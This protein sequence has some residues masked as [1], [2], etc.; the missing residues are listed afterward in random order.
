MALTQFKPEALWETW[1]SAKYT[2]NDEKPFETCI[3]AAFN[4]SKSD[5]YVY[6]AQGETTLPITQRVIAA[7]RANGLHD[8]YRIKYYEHMVD[9]PHPS[10]PFA[11]RC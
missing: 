6:R 4:I 2:P 3:R 10:Y 5:S 7:R 9:V 8:W 1:T 11:E